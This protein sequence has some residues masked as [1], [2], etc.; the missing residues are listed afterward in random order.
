MSDDEHLVI[1][2]YGFMDSINR[3]HRMV[4]C[5]LYR[6]DAKAP[7]EEKLNISMI[8]DLFGY[9]Y[10]L[11]SAYKNEALKKL[12]VKVIES[13]LSTEEIVWNGLPAFQRFNPTDDDTGKY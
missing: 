11:V 12:T 4:L 1:A 3:K 5:L 9:N 13:G 10:K 8:A 7:Y 2:M 6:G